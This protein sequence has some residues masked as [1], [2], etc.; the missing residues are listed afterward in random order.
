MAVSAAEL[1]TISVLEGGG[2][3][4]LSG[5]GIIHAT[6]AGRGHSNEWHQR[7]P[8]SG[9]EQQQIGSKTCCL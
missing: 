2:D 3:D 5:R 4:I 7:I 1:M 9:Q 8:E 6:P